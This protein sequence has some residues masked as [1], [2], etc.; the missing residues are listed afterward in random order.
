MTNRRADNRKVMPFTEHLEELRWVL[1][2][3]LIVI[4]ISAGVCFYFSKKIIWWLERPVVAVA[5]QANDA[6]ALLRALAPSEAFL[7]SMKV[8]LVAG[9]VAASPIMFYYLWG[10]VSAG[11]TRRERR[12]VIPIF[13][14]G[15]LFFLAGVAICY[16]FVLEL[17]LRFLWNYTQDMGIRPD[18]TIGRYM[19]FILRLLIAF[20]IVFE[21]PVA[22]ALLARFGLLRAR[23]L[24]AKRAYAILVIFIV[25]GILSPPDVASQILLAVPMMVLYEV[26][27]LAAKMMEKRH[28]AKA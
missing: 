5:S 17:C 21:M 3:S 11:L 6:Q 10:F 22:S 25:A 27:I 1:A 16:F 20:G 19:S 24:A 7:M 2:K 9:L 12:A 4:A 18:W 15:A 26:S 28:H 23:T 14:C 13:A 8:G